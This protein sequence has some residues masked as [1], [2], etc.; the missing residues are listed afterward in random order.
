MTQDASATSSALRSQ[1]TWVNAA[2]PVLFRIEQ[3]QSIRKLR[4]AYVKVWDPLIRIGHWTIV[5][6]FAIAYLSEDVLSLHVWAGYVVGAAV[7]IRVIWGFVGPQRARFVDFICAPRTVLAY[8]SDLVRFRAKRYLGHS[9]AGGAMI[10]ALL[11]L[12]AGTVVTGLM[13]LGSDKHAGPLAPLYAAAPA[14]GTPAAATK[15]A[16]A[17]EGEESA[18]RELH[19]LLANLTLVLVGFHVVGVVLA[20]LA[21]R[22][23]LVAAMMTGRKRADSERSDVPDSAAFGR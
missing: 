6:A 3:L 11:V 9:P 2:A 21:H 22:E 5:A 13:S 4:M 8:A 7:L 15:R 1:L 16:G 19:E 12:L 17:D 14:A 18:V 23:N 10:V 20:S